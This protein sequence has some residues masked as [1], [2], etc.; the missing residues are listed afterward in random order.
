MYDIA[1]LGE[2]EKRQ[3]SNL[4]KSDRNAYDTYRSMGLGHDSAMN[5]VKANSK[6]FT[7]FSFSELLGKSNAHS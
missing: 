7:H 6:P 3:R 1:D 5:S 4:S 2:K